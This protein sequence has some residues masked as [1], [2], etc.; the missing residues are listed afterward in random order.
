MNSQ[1]LWYL[2]RATGVVALVL[3]TATVV[4]GIVGAARAASD[5][6]PRVVT[7]GLHRNLALTATAL[8][9][10]HVVTTVLDP[11]VSISIAAAFLPFTSDY[12]PI[13]L[14][15]GALAFD[16]LLAVLITS[17]LR[18]RISHR[19]WQAV[20]LLVYACWPI[21]L[22]H[23][24][25]TGTDTRLG[26]VLAINLGCVLVVAAAICWRLSITS[27]RLL[28]TAGA[29]TMIAVVALTAIFL[30]AG[31]LKSGWPARSGTPPALL[32][33]SLLPLT[34]G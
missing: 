24:L 11:F 2:T 9:C 4:L 15:L 34:L 28:R 16:L 29:A 14:S 8:V 10:V 26:L 6:W 23:G 13:W 17:L 33:L 18:D 12:R 3:L 19:V 1:V 30:V 22:W 7:A 5:R 31:P 32:G 21:A 25:G 27:S 20:H